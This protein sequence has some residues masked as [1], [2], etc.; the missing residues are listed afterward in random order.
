MTITEA[1]NNF[2][3][4][5]NSNL[6]GLKF[7]ESNSDKYPDNKQFMKIYFLLLTGN[8]SGIGTELFRRQ[9]E[10]II[11]IFTPIQSQLVT[12]SN[13]VEEA[14]K[15]LQ[16]Y[17]KSGTIFLREIYALDLGKDPNGNFIYTNVK[18]GFIFEGS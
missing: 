2:F 1:K 5:I 10:I 11:S 15:A 9:G 18:A 12:H 6:T 3:T 16:I 8:R 7:Y 4:Y 13:K 17:S 14:L